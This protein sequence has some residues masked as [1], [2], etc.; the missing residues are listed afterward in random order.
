MCF[1]LI[2]GFVDASGSGF[3]STLEKQDKIHYRIGTW[4]SSE[5]ENSSNWRE[6]ENLVYTVEEAGRKGM[7]TGS[8]VLL[9]TENSVVEAALYK[10]NSSSE[11]L[12]DLVVR[13]RKAELHSSCKLLVTHVS[14]KRMMAQGTDDV[15]RGNLREGVAVGKE[16]LSFCPWA[17]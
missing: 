12:F 15:S 8:T 6:F 1:V 17:K 5:K 4:S 3:G 11:K 2:Y 10:G 7:L 16:V 9:A 13:L 14:G